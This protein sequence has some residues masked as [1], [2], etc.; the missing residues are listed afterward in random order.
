[1]FRSLKNVVIAVAHVVGVGLLLKDTTKLFSLSGNSLLTG[2]SLKH[3]CVVMGHLNAIVIQ[4]EDCVLSV[5]VVL[6]ECI[7][8][9][10]CIM[11]ESV[12][13]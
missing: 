4:F 7:R 3:H 13:L 10:I 12:C 9:V 8:L 2:S 6:F 11:S 1:M 5:V